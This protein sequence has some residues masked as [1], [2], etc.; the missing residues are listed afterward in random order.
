ME[1]HEFSALIGRL[2]RQADDN[3]QFYALK[4][5]A[6]AVLGYAT[7]FFLA[8]IILVCCWYTFSPLLSGQQFHAPLVAA[9]A[10]GLVT[11]VGMIRALWVHIAEPAGLRVTR[12]ET[13]R[14]FAAID[15]VA[16]KIGG[17]RVDSVSVSAE[18][19]ACIV[20]APSWGIFGNYRNHLE[21]GL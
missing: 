16:A 2:E 10:I 11:L 1:R 21:I 7:I 19:N 12:E 8:L 5:G 15:E 6:L 17:V 13:P 9:C 14:L 20:Q 4:V 3:P 18:F